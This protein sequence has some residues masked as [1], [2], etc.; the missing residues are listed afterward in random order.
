MSVNSVPTAFLNLRSKECIR[1]TDLANTQDGFWMVCRSL[2]DILA[3]RGILD[4][5]DGNGARLACDRFYDDWFLYAVPSGCD[6]VYSLLKL[7]EQEYD[8]EHGSPADGDTPGVTV[9]FVPFSFV[10]L[11]DCLEA[12]ADEFRQRLDREIDR[13]T[14]H[15]G[16]RHHADLKRYFV[17]PSAEGAYLIAERYAR[18]VAS[19][20]EN[21]VLD[22]PKRYSEI[23]RNRRSSLPAFVESVNWA[24]GRVVCDHE[25]IYLQSAEE[26]TEHERAVILATHTGNTSEYS[27]AAEVEY[28][29]RFLTSL[30]K[31]KIPFFG[32]S[33][34]DSA[35]RADM[36]IGDAGGARSAPYYRN[37]S[38]IVRRQYRSHKKL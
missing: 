18:H 3:Q 21:G 33:L 38:R 34:Y 19:F 35:I 13:V 37:G 29:A 23:S 8:G 27:F 12:P 2:S 24:A 10:A 32:R 17:N 5:P 26:L 25:R 28:H 16:Q 30:A 11:L 15:R 7:R 31:I 20:A 4:F 6:Y 22:V 14:A 9:S 1:P 36:T